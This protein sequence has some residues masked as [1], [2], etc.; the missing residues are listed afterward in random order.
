MPSTGEG[1]GIAYLEAMASGT[2]ALGLDAAGAIDALG[3]GQLGSAVLAQDLS[4]AI[5]SVLMGTR[6]SQDDLAV[7]TRTAFGRKAFS[8]AVSGLRRQCRGRRLRPPREIVQGGAD[9]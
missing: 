9:E 5:G 6:Q 7:R 8:R 2:P 1:F 4:M 3:D